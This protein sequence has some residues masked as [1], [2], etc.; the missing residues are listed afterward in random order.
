M[1]LLRVHAGAH[2]GPHEL[3]PA[4]QLHE[5]R[6]PPGSRGRRPLRGGPRSRPAH[7]RPRPASARPD[8]GRGQAPG[9][10]AVGDALA[11][12][13]VDRPRRVADARGRWG[14]SRGATDRPMG[15]FPPV[16]GAA[17]GLG[18]EAPRRGREVDEGVHE[19]AG[20]D[21]LPAALDR[22]EPDAD[23]HPAVA[24]GED[25]AVAGDDRSRRVPDVEVRLD[26]RRRR[27]AA[28]GS[29]PAAP[30]R[31]GSPGPGEVPERP[32]EARVGPV[33][34]HHVAGPDLAG[35]AGVRRAPG[36][37]AARAA[38]RRPSRP[39][40]RGPP[41]R[42]RGSAR[43]PRLPLQHRGARPWPPGRPRAGRGRG[44]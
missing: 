17:G 25:P 13:R 3:G 28:S 41:W 29:S 44:G 31:A 33:G 18:R 40:R 16:G 11:V 38:P 6:G 5:V 27:G 19:L 24:E 8:A 36:A 15:S 1:T 43:R 14:R 7:R 34:H 35:R 21:A 2:A 10:V 20:V 39:R 23:V 12:E 22:Q 4:D 9:L 26:E 32:A 37:R 42:D 30:C